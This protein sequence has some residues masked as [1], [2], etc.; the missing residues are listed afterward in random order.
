M[1]FVRRAYFYVPV[2][3][4][5]FLLLLGW[6]WSGEPDPIYQETLNDS[7]ASA[8]TT[9][10]GAATTQMLI[11]SAET[12]LNKRGGYLSNDVIPPSV[13]LDNQPNWE[14]GVL[15]QIRDPRQVVA[16]RLQSLTNAI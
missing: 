11:G 9:V 10:V 15:Q 6:Y 14:F 4:L 12:L 7:K 16:Q 2:V 3:L 8:T 13:F 5:I 1:S